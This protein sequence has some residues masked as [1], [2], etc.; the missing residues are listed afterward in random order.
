MCF[1]PFFISILW[2][3]NLI[4]IDIS[5]GRGFQK[6]TKQQK[7]GQ[8]RMH[9][10]QALILFGIMF[11][12]LISLS[13]TL[14]PSPDHFYRDYF[15]LFA[16]FWPRWPWGW[17]GFYGLIPHKAS[18]NLS[19]HPQPP[20]YP[21]PSPIQV[22]LPS[23]DRD[24]NLVKMSREG[25]GQGREQRGGNVGLWEVLL[26]LN[27]NETWTFYREW[28]DLFTQRIP[29]ACSLKEVGG[30]RERASRTIPLK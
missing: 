25:R 5:P 14:F 6:K 24:P 15:I 10:F 30:E 18:N 11:F 16:R 7:L 4:P 2:E 12:F 20:L 28:I 23:T 19:V 9:F 13:L 8:D 3:F 27:W 21:P 29:F 1:S 22:S 26:S 17:E